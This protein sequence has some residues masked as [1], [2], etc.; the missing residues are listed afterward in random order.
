MAAGDPSSP[1]V[2]VLFN[3]VEGGS[4]S[5][6]VEPS[7]DVGPSGF[8]DWTAVPPGTADGDVVLSMVIEDGQL[9]ARIGEDLTV[10]G[11]LAVLP[12]VPAEIGL[13]VVTPSDG[14]PSSCSF[15]DVTLVAQ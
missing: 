7:W 11:T 10:V 2:T 8:L 6:F 1:R 4:A 12:M 3:D 5:A 9:E 15:D 14:A 13:V